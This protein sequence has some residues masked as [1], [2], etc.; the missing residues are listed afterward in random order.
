LKTTITSLPDGI[1]ATSTVLLRTVAFA[2]NAM[3][4]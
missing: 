4:R 3:A 2:T 1:L